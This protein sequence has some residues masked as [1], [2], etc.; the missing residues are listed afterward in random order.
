VVKDEKDDTRGDEREDGKNILE[1]VE[2]GIEAKE[3]GVSSRERKE[4][5]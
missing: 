4:E 2:K 3:G 1:E 5:E